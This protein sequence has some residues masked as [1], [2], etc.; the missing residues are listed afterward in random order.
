MGTTPKHIG[1]IL[2]GNRR[3]ASKLMLPSYQ[4]HEYGA[5]KVEALLDWCMELS[6]KELT[7]YAFSMENFSRPKEE[8]KFLWKLFEKEFKK[9]LNDSRIYKHKVKINFIGRINLFPK[10]VK[11]AMHKLMDATKKHKRYVV[12]FAMAYSGRAE[13]IDAIKKLL[14]SRINEKNIN[15]KTILDNLYLTKEPDLII[16][17]SGEQRVSNFL[18]YQAAYAEWFFTKKLW[19][20]FDKKD[21]IIAINDYKQRER[22]FGR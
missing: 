14:T 15:E 10:K 8:L 19:P 5:R 7:L 17:T 22:R 9:M 3:Y 16:R 18:L 4:G 12:N 1:I 21:L 2:D 6:I 20:E 11:E 13:I